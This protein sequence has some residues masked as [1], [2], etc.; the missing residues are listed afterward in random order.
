MVDVPGVLLVLGRTKDRVINFKWSKLIPR[1]KVDK[2]FFNE[3]EGTK[4]PW[5][6]WFEATSPWGKTGL[7]LGLGLGRLDVWFGWPRAEEN[8]HYEG[9]RH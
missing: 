5:V 3:D 8:L 9:C 7:G 6:L 2:Y 4:W 1:F